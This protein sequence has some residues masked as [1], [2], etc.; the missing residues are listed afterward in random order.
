[1][2]YNQLAMLNK[3]EPVTMNFSKK[4]ILHLYRK[5]IRLQTRM[6]ELTYLFWECTLRCNF[7]CLHC[8]SDC[9][10]VSAVADMPKEDFLQVLEK[11][12]AHVNPRKVM[13]VLSGGEPLVR[14]DLEACG[15]AMYN[16][17][18]PWGLVTNGWGLSQER[19]DSLM[20][21]GLRSLS[22]SFDGYN[23]E[24]HDWFRGKKGS[25]LRALNAIS[26]ATGTAG[27]ISDVV[28]C[29]NQKNIGE[30]HQLK[31]LLLDLEVKKWRLF[32]IFPK[33]RAKNNPL[34]TLSDQ[35]FVELMEFIKEVREENKIDI[36]YGCEGYLG[37][38]EMEVRDT[39]Y[40]C[41]AGI[42]IGSV[43][44]N[45]D[46]GAC[47]TLR[48]D[49]IQGNIYT[50]DFWTVWNN[51]YQIMRDKSWTKTGKCAN[52]KSYKYCQGNALHLRDQESGELLLCHLDKIEENKPKIKIKTRSFL[53]KAASLFT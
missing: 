11:L 26:R 2:V 43:L 36:S 31:T 48:G 6:H 42:N 13:V 24:T 41:R 10:A 45:G 37:K 16:M 23:E 25:W 33:G 3:I 8:G 14:T 38:Y 1:M 53:S 44:A 9:G 39:P 35:Q 46:I 27:L 28:T 21:S 50:D 52:C 15:I 49:Y 47:P 34:L 5:H 17:G 4:S 40:F 20:Q 7:D 51:K 29:V 18:F 12:T 22:V 32:T 30:L 19:L